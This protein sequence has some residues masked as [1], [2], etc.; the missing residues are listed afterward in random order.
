MDTSDRAFHV[1]DTFEG[2]PEFSTGDEEFHPA[3]LF[4]DTGF[5]DVCAF[6]RPLQRITV[7][8]GAFEDLEPTLTGISFAFAHLDVDTYVST[9]NCLHF[10]SHSLQCGGLVVLDDFGARK[11]PGVERAA[12]EFVSDNGGYHLF[13]METE[14]AILVRF[15]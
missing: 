2:H 10:L 1:V 8:K 6:L 11:C 4:G 3:G 5:D 14:Q 13:R 7:H 12:T 9:L 15:A